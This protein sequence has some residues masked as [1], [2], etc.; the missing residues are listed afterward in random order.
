MTALSY[1][2]AMALAVQC[3]NGLPPDLLVGVALGESG[4]QPHIVS[5]KNTNGTKD[6]GFGQIN[7]ATLA[8]V[9]LTKETAQDPCANIAGM[10]RYLRILSA[11]HTGPRG[12]FDEAYVRRALSNIRRVTP[13]EVL[14]VTTLSLN[15]QVLTSPHRKPER[16]P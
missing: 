2:A 1:A 9:G 5:Q 4:L 6:N 3:G 13:A 14:P 15:D 10:A 8:L 16:R 11:Y 7:D 12:A